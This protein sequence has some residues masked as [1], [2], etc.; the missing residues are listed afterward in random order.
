MMKYFNFPYSGQGMDFMVP[1]LN[2]ETYISSNLLSPGQT[3][4]EKLKNF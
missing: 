3:W 4:S 2:N 1:E